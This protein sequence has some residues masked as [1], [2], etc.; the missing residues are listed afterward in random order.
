M[1]HDWTHF[2]YLF[3]ADSLMLVAGGV[4]VAWFLPVRA[5]VA[6]APPAEETP[7]EI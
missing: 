1:H 7:A 5:I 2:I 4:I 3:V 6:P